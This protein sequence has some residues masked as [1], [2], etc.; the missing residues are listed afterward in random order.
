MSLLIVIELPATFSFHIDVVL[1]IPLF[2]LVLWLVIRGEETGRILLRVA[3]WLGQRLL[4]FFVD[5]G[6][7]LEKISLELLFI[8]L[9]VFGLHVVYVWSRGELVR[10]LNLLRSWVDFV[11]IG[12]KLRVD[13]DAYR[14]GQWTRTK[15]RIAE[16]SG[17]VIMFGLLDGGSHDV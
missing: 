1:G 4:E 5:L 6:Y 12:A 7:R 8:V 14:F 13:N 3:H 16:G 11:S 2:L 17:P 10:C 9:L 15:I